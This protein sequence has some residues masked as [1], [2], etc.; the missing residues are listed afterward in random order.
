MITQHR[1]RETKM[2]FI[3]VVTVCVIFLPV[4]G[5]GVSGEKF[6]PVTTPPGKAVVYI[7]RPHSMRGGSAE[8]T[9]MA[10]D[11]PLTII[12]NGGY[13]PYITEPGHIK[14]TAKQRPS[15]FYIADALLSGELDLYSLS[16]EAGETYYLHFKWPPGGLGGPPKLLP[17][18]KEEGEKKLKSTKR[19]SEF[20]S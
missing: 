12:K 13:Y 7:Y 19:L 11:K 18:S 9:L 15:V 4:I 3:L 20:S 5:C 17:V 16:V 2:A 6:V 8:W 1:I 14:F 10:N